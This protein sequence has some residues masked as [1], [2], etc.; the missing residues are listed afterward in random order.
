MADAPN[1]EGILIGGAMTLAG[2]VIAQVVA[3]FLAWREREN[4]R[5]LLQLDRLEKIVTAVTESLRWFQDHSK[6]RTVED[7]SSHPPPPEARQA[8]ML[9]QL[10]FSALVE[11]AAAYANALVEY[12]HLL[13]DCLDPNIPASATA[14]VLIRMKND[15]TLEKR[16][17]AHF[18][19]RTA[20]DAAI[21]TEAK[22]YR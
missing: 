12:H 18:E 3:S 22:K 19:A 6:L 4:K 13:I 5:K 7:I 8:A 15:P 20:L 10:Y 17:M 2:T 9:A 21:A 11:P 16:M 14:H 1:I